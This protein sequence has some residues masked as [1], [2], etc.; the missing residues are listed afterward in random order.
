M[1]EFPE[2]EQA[3][4]AKAPAT[5]RTQASFLDID[6][7][8]KSAGKRRHDKSRVEALLALAL[9]SP[10]EAVSTLTMRG[11]IFLPLLLA[12][13]VRG[14]AYGSLSVVIGI[15]LAREG[16]T[17]IQIGGLL[18]LT[19]LTGAVFSLCSAGIARRTGD[20]P[21]LI[22][23]CI[24]MAIAGALLASDISTPL[25]VVAFALGSLTAGGQDVGPFA[26]L[27]QAIIGSR[28]A[29]ISSDRYATYNTVGVLCGALGAAL[30]AVVP[31]AAVLWFYA[32]ASIVM[33][34]AYAALPVFEP[35]PAPPARPLRRFG[36]IEQLAALFAV[37]ALAGGFVVQAVIAYWFHLRFG[38]PLTALGPLFAAANLLSALSFFAAAR[39]AKRF[40]LLNTMVFTHLPSNVLLALVP[41]MPSF[42]WAGGVLLARFALSQMDV[43][44]RQAYV[45]AAAAPHDRARAASL[46]SAVRPAAAAIAPLIAGVAMQTAAFGAPFVIAGAMKIAYDFMLFFRFRGE[47]PTR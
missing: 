8:E 31:I 26:P 27:E 28:M 37:D 4:N 33:C 15:V 14:L 44:T 7:P 5:P 2:L 18:S 10:N 39:L 12:R 47:R 11:T 6:A 32:A 23:G 17:A 30:V 45:M 42:E 29:E 13:A 24:L 25:V 3:A 16:F 22:A 38:T 20:K 21:A 36:P 40:G 46:T 9:Q 41:F 35:P 19:L 34:I 43:P 1:E